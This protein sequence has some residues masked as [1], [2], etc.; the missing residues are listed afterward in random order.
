MEKSGWTP[1]ESEQQSAEDPLAWLR[2]ETGRAETMRWLQEN[3]IRIDALNL[4]SAK[5]YNLL[6]LNER[7]CLYQLA[8]LTTEDI[9]EIPRMDTVSASEIVK[10]TDAY[11]CENAESIFADRCHS[12][13]VLTLD[14]MRFMPEHQNSILEFVLKN[15]IPVDRM[16]ITARPKN[17]LQRNGFHK[18]SD[19]IFLEEEELKR[20]PSMGGTSVEQIQE[21]IRDYLKKHRQI[22]FYIPRIGIWEPRKANTIFWKTSAFL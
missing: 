9:L 13:P 21:A 5:A 7:E 3:Q 12:N 2:S 8:F 14:Q 1:E 22:F 11:I 4:L 20:L 10:W 17:Q 19:I 16:S 15:D 6:M 18:L